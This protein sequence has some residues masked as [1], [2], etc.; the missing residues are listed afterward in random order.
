MSVNE[1]FTFTSSQKKGIFAVLILLLVVIGVTFSVR[2]FGNKEVENPNLE[3]P[4]F[5]S[6]V[7]K[8]QT[9]NRLD[10]N[11]ADSAQLVKLEGIGPVLASRIINYRNSKGGFNS[12]NEVARVYGL[13]NETFQHISSSLFVNAVTAPVQPSPS[14]SPSFVRKPQR[15]NNIEMVLDINI[16][17]ADDFEKLPGIG[18][19]L[20]KRIVKYRESLK[21]FESVNELYKVYNLDKKVVD[22][23]KEYLIVN[24][25]T[26][27]DIREIQVPRSIDPNTSKLIAANEQKTSLNALLLD[28]GMRS[29]NNTKLEDLIVN[30]N[31]ADSA[32][33]T[34][35]PGIGHI[36]ATRIIK[37]RKIIGFYHSVENLNE[38]YGIPDDVV[39]NLKQFTTVGDINQFNNTRR[40]LNTATPVRL[41][42][43]PGIDLELANRINHKRAQLGRFD[44]WT[45]VEEINGITPEVLETLKSYF[46]I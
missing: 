10:I 15:Q 16:A 33:L 45:E 42:K 21:G 11:L 24:E 12:V 35:L 8:K 5:T 25:R 7:Y 14:E 39:E 26:L 23:N 29:E 17:S 40:D 18:P 34:A 43:Y 20:S 27:S 2:E 41:K 31:T 28:G 4:Y 32:T 6:P 13:P 46:V 38:V 22:E 1:N 9:P 30:I 19:V 36:Y 44:T 3:E 37:Y